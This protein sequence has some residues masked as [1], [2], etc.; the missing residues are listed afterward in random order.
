MG[1]A[2]D[3]LP[4]GVKNVRSNPSLIG[5]SFGLLVVSLVVAAPLAVVAVVLSFVPI[6]GQLLA[7]PLVAIPVKTLLLGGM[8]GLSGAGFAGS[9]G[10]DDLKRTYSEHGVSLAAA[11][12]IYELLLVVVSIALVVVMV[13]VVL[14]G[15]VSATAIQSELAAGG[16]GVLIVAMYVGVVVLLAVIAA[17]F[18]F[19][20]VAVVLGEKSATG[21]VGECWRLVRNGPLSVA[22]YTLLRGLVGS[23]ILLPGYVLVLL[24]EFTVDALTYVGVVVAVLLYP[25]AFAVLMSYH[26][27]YYGYRVRD[28]Q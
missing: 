25:V 17:V 12:A 11:F 26:A 21:A 23:L 2:I 16:L 13:V 10:V 1:H 15:T 9:V 19:L 28:R 14:G 7:R 4:A 18:Q 8:V 5:Y 24:G 27:A 22:G 6:F 20:D 3:A